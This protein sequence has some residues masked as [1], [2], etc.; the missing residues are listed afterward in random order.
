MPSMP[1]GTVPC[2]RPQSFR[3]TGSVELICFAL[4]VAQCVYLVTSLFQG[5]WIIDASGQR[6]ATDFVNVW[7]ADGRSLPE[8]RRVPM[9]PRFTRTRKLRLSDIHSLVSTPGFIRPRSSSWQPC[10]PR[11]RLFRPT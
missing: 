5:S 3:L 9:T 10:L 1:R 2:G 6:I 7:R 11:F 8:I 4:C